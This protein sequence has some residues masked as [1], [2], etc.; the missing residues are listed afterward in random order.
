MQGFGF[1][2]PDDG[3][4]DVFAHGSEIASDGGEPTLVKGQ[5][6]TYD[7]NTGPEGIQ[8]RSVMPLT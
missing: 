5:R 1:I 6:V 4:P 3:G 2:T 7:V 8:A